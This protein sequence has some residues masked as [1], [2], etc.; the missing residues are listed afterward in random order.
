[1]RGNNYVIELM[2][3][4]KNLISWM[5]KFHTNQHGKTCSKNTRKCTK[6][7]IKCSNIFM[8][9]GKE[10]SVYKFHHRFHPFGVE[11][12]ASRQDQNDSDSQ[13]EY[14]AEL[15]HSTRKILKMRLAQSSSKKALAS[16]FSRDSIFF[17]RNQIQVSCFCFFT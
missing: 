11:A 7:K 2:I 5:S 15:I 9:C 3:P 4:S 6:N 12:E 1:M 10:P 16:V 14:S 8:V 17:A 13:S